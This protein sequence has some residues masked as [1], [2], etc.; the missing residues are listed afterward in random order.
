[1]R[2]Q[3]NSETWRATAP[4]AHR[5]YVCDKVSGGPTYTPITADVTS[6]FTTGDEYQASHRIDK[7]VNELCPAHIWQLCNT[8][9]HQQPPPG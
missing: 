5:Q 9:A 4:L 1:M 8:A 2:V 7:A 6:D 3:R